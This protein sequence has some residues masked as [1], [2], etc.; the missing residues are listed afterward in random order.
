M[1]NN[2]LSGSYRDPSGFVFIRNNRLLRQINYS[3]KRDCDFLTDFQVKR[4]LLN[5][6]DIYKGYN[7]DKFEKIFDK[8]F[9]IRFKKKV[10]GSQRWL[11]L[12]QKKSTN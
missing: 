9:K 12:M 10:R 1:I 8:H 6:K 11:Y 7:M 3:Y 2:N 4:L 5:K